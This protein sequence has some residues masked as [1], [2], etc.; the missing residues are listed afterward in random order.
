MAR[1]R[2]PND[3]CNSQ[4]TDDLY[5]TDAS[6]SAVGDADADDLLDV[7]E[8]VSSPESDVTDVEDFS[9][10]NSNVADQVHLFEGNVHP[11]KYYQKALR[12][13]NESAFDSGNY[14][15]GSTVLLDAIEK[16]WRT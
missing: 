13:F 4:V 7:D 8:D 16:Q 6:F 3:P 14:S 11:P 2:V 1:Q 12:E 5:E 10:D 9:D 15:L